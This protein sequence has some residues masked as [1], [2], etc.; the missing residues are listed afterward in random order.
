M[1]VCHQGGRPNFDAEAL[2]Y[3]C[4]D[5]M[6]VHAECAAKAARKNRQ[7][8]TDTCS[9]L[10]KDPIYQWS[11]HHGTAVYLSPEFRACEEQFRREEAA[12]TCPAV[13][14]EAP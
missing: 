8:G 5:G 12:A 7:R 4:S 2:Q 9:C 13:S 10:R 1:T 14:G 3:T 6:H 11:R